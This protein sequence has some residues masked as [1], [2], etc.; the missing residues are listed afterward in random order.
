[1]TN[2]D[3]QRRLQLQT[4]NLCQKCGKRPTYRGGRCEP[5]YERQ[6]VQNGIWRE[7]VKREAMDNYG[8]SSCACCGETNMLMLTLDHVCQDG[9]SNRRSGRDVT[10]FRFYSKLKQ[11]GYPPGFRVLCFNCNHACFYSEDGRCPHHTGCFASPDNHHF[12]HKRKDDKHSQATRRC[13]Q[14][15]RAEVLLQYGAGCSCCGETELVML[16]IDHI[17]QDGAER[18]RL[19]LDRKGYGLYRQ[20]KRLRYPPG[21][22]VLCRNC[23]F[24]AFHSGG[25][26]PHCLSQAA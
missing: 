21:Y 13:D 18:R 16:S 19:G 7:R 25:E 2:Y 22:R 10:G 5:C 12:G 14:K 6:L 3:K 11:R 8:G 20:L 23:N 4:R 15:L 1:M 26:C 9:A 24:A 17:A